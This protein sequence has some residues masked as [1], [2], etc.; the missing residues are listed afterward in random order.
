MIHLP[1]W[2]ATAIMTIHR[3]RFHKEREKL[4]TGEVVNFACIW[5]EKV[6]ETSRMRI[7]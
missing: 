2:Y 4:A 6:L 1:W 3:V 7:A 5:E